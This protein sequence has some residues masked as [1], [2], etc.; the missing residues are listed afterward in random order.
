MPSIAAYAPLSPPPL[1][2]CAVG[3]P[4]YGGAGGP[5]WSGG[6]AAAAAAAVAPSSPLQPFQLPQRRVRNARAP[7]LAVAPP[8]RLPSLSPVVGSHASHA[9]CGDD[10]GMHGPAAASLLPPGCFSSRPTAVYSLPAIAVAP[11]MKVLRMSPIT[12]PAP[13]PSAKAK[14]K[15]E[16]KGAITYIGMSPTS[17]VTGGSDRE[18]SGGRPAELSPAAPPMRRDQR[19]YGLALASADDQKTP[20][21]HAAPS[22]PA[23][24]PSSGATYRRGAPYNIISNLP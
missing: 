18:N 14:T 15:E 4:S 17:T 2:A 20:P 6:Y 23:V 9:S 22:P 3:D 10:K 12:S 11:A 21:T 5:V 7:Y 16:G 19:W 24:L 8:P 13:S 1:S